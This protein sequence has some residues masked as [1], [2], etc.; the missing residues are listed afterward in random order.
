MRRRPRPGRCRRPARGRWR[1]ACRARERCPSA[2]SQTKIS[3]TPPASS[4]AARAASSSGETVTIQRAAESR[5]CLAS[6]SGG[7]ERVHGGD[8]RAGAGGA[9]E[10]PRVE[11]CVFGLCSASDVALADARRRRA[12][13]AIR[14]LKRVQ[15]RVAE[16]L[17][18]RRRRSGPAGRRT[19][20]ARPRTASWIG[21]VDARGR[22]R[23]RCGTPSAGSPG[24]CAVH[25]CTDCRSDAQYDLGRPSVWWAT[26]LRIISRLT[27]AI[28]AT[29]AA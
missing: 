13:A 27:G 15:L 11:R 4:A 8:G 7:G 10:R 21:Q 1:R 20:A 29:R 28:R 25:W 12:P 9:V 26:K 22:R 17:A 5:S 19:P 3:R 16:R 14:R 2:W 24:R 23:T 18:R 6:S